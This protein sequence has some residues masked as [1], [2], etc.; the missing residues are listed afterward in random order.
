MDTL[1][2]FKAHNDYFWQWEEGGE[3]IAM[4]GGSTICYREQLITLLTAMSHDGIPRLG[5]LLLVLAAMNPQPEQVFHWAEA[6]LSER[7]NQP[8]TKNN[9][10][11]RDPVLAVL[12]LV[13]ELPRKYK[14]GMG[15]VEA[16]RALFRGCHN[17]INTN[18]AGTILNEFRQIRFNHEVYTVKDKYHERMMFTEFSVIANLA[19]KFKTVEDIKDRIA[20]L[21]RT[22]VTEVELEEDQS[23]ENPSPADFVEELKQHAQTFPVGSLVRRIWSGLNIPF[24]NQLPSEQ[25]MGGVSDI[26]N[27][28]DFHRLLTTEFANDDITFL[29]RLANNEALYLNREVPPQS[30]KKERV[31][32]IDV[33][34]RNWGTPKTIA[35]ALLVAIARHPKT[36]IPCVAYAV[37]DTYAPINFET[38]DDIIAS[39]HELAGCLH[40]GKGLR[41]FLEDFQRNRNMEL[42]FIS[43]PDTLKIPG[44]SVAIQDYLPLFRFWLVVNQE[45][46]VDVY[47]NQQNSRKHHQHFR[48]P[49]DE[50]WKAGP[51]KTKVIHK[52]NAPT[53]TEYP[54]LF[55]GCPHRRDVMI[56]PDGACFLIGKDKCVY[57]VHAEEDSRLNRR[58]WEMVHESLMY[59]LGKTAIG[60]NENGE[61]VVLAHSPERKR[62]IVVNLDTKDTNEFAFTP[63]YWHLYPDYFFYNGAFHLLTQKKCRIISITGE[64]TDMEYAEYP[65]QELVNAWKEQEERA[66]SKE[67]NLAWPENYLRKINAVGITAQGQLV[68]NKHVLE[69]RGDSVCWKPMHAWPESQWAGVQSKNRFLFGIQYV[70]T[71]TESGMLILKGPVGDKVYIPT[72]IDLSLGLATMNSF[73]GNE[74]Y[75][76]PLQD[77]QEIIPVEKFRDL[78][79]EPFIKGI[80][81]DATHHKA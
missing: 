81:A 35:Y 56:A 7:P 64:L 6:L 24:H 61:Y 65:P 78:F 50:L 53:P 38:V 40:P 26:T 18:T 39:M 60:Q 73:C 66:K 9:T 29:S 77:K 46:D 54:I 10:Y 52:P 13:A 75:H 19:T 28:G 74:Y 1:I 5:S 21:P 67:R 16:L 8:A 32:L 80:Q 41:K 17:S 43:N 3:V 20:G 37:G 55:P 36:D 62:T 22:I 44:L 11:L 34:I 68:I 63:H 69:F 71:N 76:N 12:K 58:G 47:R 49:L 72:A 14:E 45:G 2:Y 15:K 70:I 48:L 33:S 31:I 25:P 30:N 57:R 4:P 23:G 51:A 27:K 59:G 79:I 42:I